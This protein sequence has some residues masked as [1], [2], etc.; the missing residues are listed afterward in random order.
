MAEL[1]L[2]NPQNVV[3][4]FYVDETCIDCDL[5]RNIAPQVYKRDEETGVSFVFR[6]PVTEAEIATA[7]EG[8]ISCPTDSIG[9]DG[10]E[11][12]AIRPN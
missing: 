9:C 1:K 5:C 2:K 8:R 6:Q 11:E 4:K 3:G 7:E 12:V 10:V